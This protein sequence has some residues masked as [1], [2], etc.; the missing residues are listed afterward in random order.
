MPR[1]LMQGLVSKQAQSH[2]VPAELTVMQC[3]SPA[4]KGG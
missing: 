3:P 4:A 2:I 1:Q